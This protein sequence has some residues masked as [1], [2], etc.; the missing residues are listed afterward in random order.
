MTSARVIFVC[1]ERLHAV[2][3]PAAQ[4]FDLITM[5]GLIIHQQVPFSGTHFVYFVYS[6]KDLLVFSSSV[7]LLLAR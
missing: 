3:S 7:L 6:V 4:V 5:S 1:N 2:S